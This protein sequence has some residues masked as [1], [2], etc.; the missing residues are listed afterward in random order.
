MLNYITYLNA[1]RLEKNKK[2]K[3]AMEAY[4]K[5][6]KGQNNIPAKLAY[7]IG[8]VAEKI[9][10]WK[11]AEAWL[12]KAVKGQPDKA[13][14]LYRLALAQEKN[15][16]YA[17]AIGSYN[18]ALKI[19]PEKTEWVYRSGLCN[20]LLKKYPQALARY[21]EALK[22]MPDVAEWQYRLGKV[23]WLSGQGALAEEPLR[24]AMELEPQ[25]ALYAHELSVAI[26]K[27]GRTWQEVEVL[28]HTLALDAGKAQW[29]FEQGEAQ[30]KMNRFGEAG[31]AFREANRLKPGN[32]MWH[33]REGYAWEKAGERKLAESAYAAARSCDKDLKAK[34][35]GVGVFHQ[36]RGLWPQAAMAYENETK[37]QPFNGELLYRLGLAHDRCYR[38]EK[39]AA[40]YKQALVFEPHKADWHYRLGFVLERQGLLQQA[41]QAYEYAATTKTTHTP[42]WFYRLG[43]VLAGAGE[44]EKACTAFLHTRTQAQLPSQPV[45]EANLLEAQTVLSEEYLDLLK[46]NLRSLQADGVALQSKDQATALY[47]LGNQAERLQMWEE[48]AQAYKSAVERASLHNGNWYYR[49]GYVLVQ[50]NLFPEAVKAF[51]ETR[52]FKK[53]YGMGADSY[54]KNKDLMQSLIYR[55]YFDYLSI[56]NNVIMYESNQGASISCSPWSIFLHLID[57]F[58]YRDFVHVWVV[59]D[60][61]KIPQNLLRKNNIIF[62]ER[63]SDLYLRYLSSAKFLIN[64]NTFPPYFVRKVDQKYLNTWHG[65]PLKFLGRDMIDGFMEHRNAARN[66]I[67]AT[68]II[69]PNSHTTKV[70]TEGYDIHDIYSGVIAETGYPRIDRSICVDENKKILIKKRL[71]LEEGLPVVLY[72]PT[73]RGTLTGGA[74]FDVERLKSDIEILN[75]LKCNFLFRGHHMLE[76]ILTEQSLGNR[77][78]VPADIDTNDLLSVV[79][80]LITDYSSIFFDFLPLNRPIVFYAYDMEE[81]IRERGLYFSMS[82]MPGELCFEI[83]DV[84]ENINIILS[85]PEKWLPDNKYIAAQKKFCGIEDGL[86]TKRAVDFF[87]RDAKDHIV[88]AAKSNRRS[89]LLYAGPLM[90]NGITSAILNLLKALDYS[91]YDVTMLIDAE[92][93]KHNDRVD[94]MKTISK[95]V[96]LI[97][98]VGRQLQNIEQ[99]W[100][101][102]NYYS[103]NNLPEGE[104]SEIYQ[105]SFAIEY[106]RMLSFSKFDV[107]L[108]FDGYNRFW[109]SL[110]GLGTLSD[111]KIIYLHNSMYGEWKRKYP[112][113]AGVFKLYQYYEKLISV[114]KSVSWENKELISQEFLI[115]VRKFDYCNNMVNADE[116]IEKSQDFLSDDI[117]EKIQKCK[118]RLFIGCGRLSPEKGFEKLIKSFSLVVEKYPESQLLILGDGPL[119]EKLLQEIASKELKGNIHLLGYVSNPYPVIAQASCFVFSSDYEGQGLVALEAL[120]LGR[121]VIST[122]VVGP[123]SILENGEGVLVENNAESLA[124]AM[125]SFIENGAKESTFNYGEY[126]REA[127]SQFENIVF[128]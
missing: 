127:I 24:K 46:S 123:R 1:R 3:P 100:I 84:V 102:D 82:E 88:S 79:D 5:I 31:A 107:V 76:N 13:Q 36:H 109:A 95:N 90:P 75:N 59:N 50:L 94:R 128:H 9:Q 48:A 118:G 81:Y 68:H 91:K 105:E 35:F 103:S 7:R 67:Q 60:R 19:N 37:L 106:Q 47:K 11:N 23:L 33:Y 121:P 32:A 54:Q 18:K 92:D 10:D 30:D 69:S 119:R 112:Y 87:L 2:W 116:I 78:V 99:K 86:S 17:A 28:E 38:W 64:N 6:V 117:S 15:K 77:F 58:D 66:F 124:D 41:A 97:A 98:R 63:E 65:T 125:I 53:A 74:N 27:Q 113:L 72:A 101:I 89:I 71:G 122:D 12:A 61:K 114:S 104:G 73:W 57:D 115:D 26:R 8:F 55:E 70:L 110:L 111:N 45:P 39:A 29:Q 120:I 20:E 14:W 40:C 42:Y 52:I 108:N 16:K 96:R 21:Q 85:S 93:L 56:E 83:S 80:L 4:K 34:I 49:L 25:N 62:V 126:A 51:R 43:Y 22:K 44:Y